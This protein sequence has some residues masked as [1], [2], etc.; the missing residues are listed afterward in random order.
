MPKVWNKRDKHCPKDA[1]HIGRPSKW[2][3]PFKIGAFYSR[4]D[5]IALYE[6]YLQSSP[7]LI[8]ALTELKGKDLACWCAPLP[9]HGD[10]LLRLAN[11][12]TQ[13]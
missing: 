12:E 10:V 5:V 2:G 3:N 7:Q 1:V 4:T 6:G 9:C 11:K 13:I 8:A